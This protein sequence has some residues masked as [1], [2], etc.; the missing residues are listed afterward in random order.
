MIRLGDILVKG[1]VAVN[2][3]LPTAGSLLGGSLGFWDYFVLAIAIIIGIIL[4]WNILKV[5]IKAFFMALL[6]VL[7]CLGTIKLLALV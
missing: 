6:L 4:C 7:L 1:D 2:S 3:T 5:S